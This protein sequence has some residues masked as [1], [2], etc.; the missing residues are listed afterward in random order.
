MKIAVSATE[1]KL[2]AGVD[3]RFG[4]CKYFV[5]VDTDT[6]D[7][8]TVDNSASLA[9]GGA[10]VAT[11]QMIAGKGVA[12]V[13]TGNCGPNAYQVLSPAGIKVIT[14][15]FGSVKEAVE[16]Y[17]VGKYEEASQSNVPD[18]FGKG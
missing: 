9:S 11:A 10:G 16:S 14:G 6:M 13:L 7:F 1:P 18:H 3:E 17:K 5:I 2:E 15:V 8:E 12:A 4:R